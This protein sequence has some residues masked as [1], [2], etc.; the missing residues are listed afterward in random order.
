LRV[1][2]VCEEKGC[3]DRT[4]GLDKT[5]GQWTAWERTAVD[6]VFFQGP[7]FGDRYGI[8][9]FTIRALGADVT[10]LGTVCATATIYLVLPSGQGRKAKE[11]LHG[12]FEIPVAAEKEKLNGGMTR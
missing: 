3:H 6:L 5:V 8:L 11:I 9:D 4:A 12:A 10:L 2:L 1:Y 7:H